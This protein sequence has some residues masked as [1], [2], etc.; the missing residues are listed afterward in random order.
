MWECVFD[1]EV[2]EQKGIKEFAPKYKL[3]YCIA[4]WPLR[5][6][7]GGFKMKEKK[8]IEKEELLHACV[9]QQWYSEQLQKGYSVMW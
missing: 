7:G 8:C 6:E 1:W 4:N 2:R 3:I 5:D 9:S